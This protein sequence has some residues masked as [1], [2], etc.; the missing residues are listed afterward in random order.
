MNETAT[1]TKTRRKLRKKPKPGFSTPSLPIGGDREEGIRVQPK[2]KVWQAEQVILDVICVLVT[3]LFTAWFFRVSGSGAYALGPSDHPLYIRL[4]AAV[5]LGI[6]LLFAWQ[7]IY[8]RDY[9]VLNINHSRR[10]LRGTF[11]GVTVM[12][13]LVFV[14]QDHPAMRRH[15]ILSTFLLPLLLTGEKSILGSMVSKRLQHVRGEKNLLILGSHTRGNHFLMR[16]FHL[17]MLGYE[18]IGFLDSD[19]AKT[20]REIVNTSLEITGNLSVLGSYEDLEDVIAARSVSEIWINDPEMPPEIWDRIR[21]LCE[22][23]S[24]ACSL[25]PSIFSYTA[26][27]LDVINLDGIPVVRFQQQVKRSLFDVVKRFFDIVFATVAILLTSPLMILLAIL[28]R[29]DTPGPALFR[30]ERIGENGK[31]FNMFKFRSMYIDTP[32]YMES[33]LNQNDPRITRVGRFIRKTSLDELPQLFNVFLGDMSV[34]GPRPEMP[35][36]VRHYDDLERMRLR[37]KPGIT[38]LWQIS[39]D[40]SIPIHKNLDYDLFYLKNRSLMLD[41]TIMWRTVGLMLRGI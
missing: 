40:R 3:F 1:A 24:V 5:S 32:K 15:L 14:F 2:L 36:I 9:S 26:P 22:N 35:F 19:P 28:I 18:L 25:I 17:R 39:A 4:S 23:H 38:G 33:P 10:F 8:S 6:I 41:L 11:M 21:G 31:P 37:V 30:Q 13:I 29:S 20:G 16:R 27:Q 7:G 12:V 34:V